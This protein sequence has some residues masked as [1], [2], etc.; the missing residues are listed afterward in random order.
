MEDADSL[1]TVCT[2]PIAVPSPKDLHWTPNTALQVKHT[3]VD[4]IC[5]PQTLLLFTVCKY[6]SKP[7]TSI[8]GETLLSQSAE[9]VLQKVTAF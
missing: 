8:T 4:K 9:V 5:F 2:H 6:Y 7:G 1:G 3:V